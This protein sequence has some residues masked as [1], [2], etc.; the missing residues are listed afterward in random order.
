M[1]TANAEGRHLLVVLC[2]ASRQAWISNGA[3]ADGDTEDI[4]ALLILIL[5]VVYENTV[6]WPRYASEK[7]EMEEIFREMQFAVDSHG[8][9]ADGQKPPLFP[10]YR[11]YI[12]QNK[13]KL[14]SIGTIGP[15][16]I[17]EDNPLPPYCFKINR[18]RFSAFWLRSCVLALHRRLRRSGVVRTRSSSFLA[19]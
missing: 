15:A 14:I 13:R 9:S 11:M 6:F 5:F 1:V 4:P 18:H 7:V 2:H 8:F 12:S 16:D 3:A 19:L 10:A 17:F